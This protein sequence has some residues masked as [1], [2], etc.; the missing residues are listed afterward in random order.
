[1]TD[2]DQISD[3][4]LPAW[5]LTAGER[6]NPASDLR[7]WTTGNHVEPLVDGAS[8]F[9]HLHQAL[10]AAGPLDQIYLADFRADTEDGI[11][12]GG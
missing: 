7:A 1:M 3:A 9:A 6:R 8:Y 12:Q 4:A 11:C 10:T 2:D 5:F